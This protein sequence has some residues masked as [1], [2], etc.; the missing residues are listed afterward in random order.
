MSTQRSPYGTHSMVRRHWLAGAAAALMGARAQSG[1]PEVLRVGV[2]NDVADDYARFLGQRDVAAVAHF[3]G[4][5]ARRDVME[6]AYL[7]REVAL[8]PLAPRVQL[9]RIDSFERLLAELAAQRL[10]ALGFSV[11]R[12][13]LDTQGDAVRASA[14]VL[15]RGQFVVGIY[16]RADNAAA[17]GVRTLQQLRTLRFVCNSGW[18]L[19][20]RTLR[21]LGVNPAFDVKTWAQMVQLVGYGRADAVLAPFQATPDLSLRAQEQTL[22]PIAGLAVALDGARHFTCSR[23][24]AAKWLEKEVFTAVARHARDGSLRRAYEECGFFPQ[25]TRGW[26]VLSP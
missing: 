3:G 5:H 24:P 6:L 12:S 4:A 20:W 23:T 21:K 9:V 14:A 17:L 15:A 7:L 25:S 13:D 11:W 22:V 18:T 16:T 19:D 2:P 26:T 8:R 1:A 10:D